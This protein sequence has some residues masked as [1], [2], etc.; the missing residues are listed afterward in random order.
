MRLRIKDPTMVEPYDYIY[1]GDDAIDLDAI[2]APEDAPE[3]VKVKF[4]PRD[5]FISIHDEAMLTGDISKI[6]FKTGQ[7]PV[8]WKMQHLE[9]IVRRRVQDMCQAD[10]RDRDTITNTTLYHACRFALLEV[11][12][13]SD[14]MNQP[15]TNLGHYPETEAWGRAMSVSVAFMEAMRNVRCGDGRTGDTLIDELG[16][17]AIRRMLVEGKS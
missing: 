10:L 8:T 11:K 13:L 15:V 6:P 17:I 3:D 5:E 12:N 9:G 4:S 7:R 1:R 16:S 2:R 14:E